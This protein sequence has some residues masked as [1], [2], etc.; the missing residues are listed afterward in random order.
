MVQPTSSKLDALR[1]KSQKGTSEA[2]A[3][4]MAKRKGS[5]YYQSN[6]V[7]Q[8][9]EGEK[10]ITSNELQIC[11][12]EQA[13]IKGVTVPNWDIKEKSIAKKFMAK[14]GSPEVALRIVEYTFRHWDKLA[15]KWRMPDGSVPTI[16]VIS[17]YGLSLINVAKTIEDKSEVVARLESGVIE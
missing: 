7:L 8:N 14:V 5:D 2:H 15:K 11:Y 3:T 10:R 12:L 9:N 13:R 4:K 16:S 1:E 17:V 6:T